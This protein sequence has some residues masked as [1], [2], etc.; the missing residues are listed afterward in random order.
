[1][2]SVDRTALDGAGLSIPGLVNR[3]AEP[4]L[5]IPAKGPMM[6]LPNFAPPLFPRLHQW[7]TE[8]NVQSGMSAFFRYRC[9]SGPDVELEI[10][11]TTR[12]PAAGGGEVIAGELPAGRYAHAVHT[13]PYDRL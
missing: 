10:G 2:L 6:D 12:E 13:G 9:F 3:K 5:A 8:R 1:M 4:Y 7:M 11:T